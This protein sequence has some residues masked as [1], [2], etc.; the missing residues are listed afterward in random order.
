ML[1]LLEAFGGRLSNIDLQ[2]YLFLFTQI[3]Q[4]EKSYEFV[5]FKYGC[6]SFQSYADRR[7]LTELGALKAVEAW[8]LEDD[9]TFID[10]IK[11]DDRKKIELF[12][13][14]Y[15]AIN[16]NDLVREVY[17]KY[18]YFAIRSEIA[19]DIMSD[20]EL[21]Q[22]Q[23]AKPASDSQC[24]YTIGYEGTSFENYL[25][26]LIKNNITVLVDVRK[27]PLSRKYGFS[28]KTLSE[29]LGKLEIAY[30]HIPELGIASGKRQS[31]NNQSDYDRLFDE[32]EGTVLKENIA[33]VRQ[34]YNVFMQYK[35]VAI[36]CF[37]A[38]VCMCHR[39]RVA[40]ALQALPEWKY[41]IQHI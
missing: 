1:S 10:T 35:R 3:C 23:G 5:P 17:K 29:T 7:K 26:R 2:K 13:Q 11:A 34:L 24:F 31:L 22:I 9:V 39:G 25:N 6:F 4:Q 40:K 15:N 27:N 30:L 28:K 20:A 12:Q 36:T 38:E 37:E 32:Y 14:K 33:S 8:E 21:A 41:D 18:P 16:G 19:N